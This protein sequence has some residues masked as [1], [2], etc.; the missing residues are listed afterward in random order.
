MIATVVITVKTG[1]H[2]LY[3]LRVWKPKTFRDDMSECLWLPDAQRAIACNTATFPHASQLVGS[4]TEVHHK[5]VASHQPSS[6]FPCW[7]CCLPLTDVSVRT[8]IEMGLCDR[9]LLLVI[10]HRSL[11]MSFNSCTSYSRLVNSIHR[12]YDSRW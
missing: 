5:T 1:H 8:L 6:S 2:Q 12:T 10:C 7:Q 11:A 9:L 4:E 3:P